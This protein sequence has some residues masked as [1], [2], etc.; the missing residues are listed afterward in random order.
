[1]LIIDIERYL[2]LRRALGF[3][4]QAVAARLRTFAAFAVLRGETHVRTS[5]ASDWA[6]TAPS[7]HARHRR[8]REVS[9]FAR[10]AHAEDVRHE[11]P[12]KALSRFTPGKR[13]P[14]IYAPEEIARLIAATAHLPR[15]SSA[16]QSMYAIFFGLIATTG[17]RVAEALNL[18]FDDLLPGGILRIRTTKFGKTRLV[19]L[20]ATVVAALA[21]YVK[22]R[23][24]V[25]S[26][27][28]HLFLSKTRKPL[29]HGVARYAFHQLLQITGIG[30]DRMPPPRIHDLRHT[31]AT[32]ALERCSTR[33][34]EVGRHFIALSTYMGH[35]DVASTFWYLQATPEMMTDIAAAAA[36]L[37]D[38]RRP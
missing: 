13:P 9:R 10:F 25:P 2:A 32:R 6:A 7:P 31:F 18:R 8:L 16:H 5:T 12:A 30:A 22:A 11:V 37:I 34:D 17:L 24:R 38:R 33:R 19:P 27:D 21:P 35:V 14:Y 23:R 36:A 1:M 3:K 26:T 20:H 4:L 15:M 29:P 28:D